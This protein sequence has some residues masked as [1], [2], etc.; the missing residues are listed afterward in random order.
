MT[1]DPDLETVNRTLAVTVQKMMADLAKAD[2][3]IRQLRAEL[4]EAYRIAH[5]NMGRP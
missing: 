3:T 1:R 4:V 5:I 2:E